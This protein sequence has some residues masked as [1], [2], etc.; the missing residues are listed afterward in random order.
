[1]DTVANELHA[2]ITQNFLFG[3]D[4][5]FDNKDSFLNLGVIDSTGV[6]E[7]VSYVEE[8]YEIEVAPEEIVPEN[9]DSVASLAGFVTKKLKGENKH[10]P[11]PSGRPLGHCSLSSGRNS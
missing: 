3:K 9:F 4:I 2:Y 8:K 1:M 6:L 11:G 7:L 5:G 10:D